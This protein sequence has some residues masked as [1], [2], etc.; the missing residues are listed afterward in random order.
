[1]M[2]EGTPTELVKSKALADRAVPGERR[3][4]KLREKAA[5]KSLR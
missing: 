2:S 3:G 4:V 1:M 5:E